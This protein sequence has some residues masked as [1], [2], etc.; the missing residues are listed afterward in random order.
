MAVKMEKIAVIQG[1]QAEI[2]KLVV[3]L[4][5]EG[6][7]ETFQVVFHE[8]VVDEIEFYTP[9]YVFFKIFRIVL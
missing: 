7:P 8:F 5:P 2:G 4:H 3:T 9:T 1:L 6:R